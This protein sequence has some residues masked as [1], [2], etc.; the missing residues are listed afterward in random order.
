MIPAMDELRI[1][2]ARDRDAEGLISLIETVFSEYPGCVLDV[3][4]EEPELLAIDTRYRARNGHFWV[5]ERAGCIVASAGVRPGSDAETLEL[6]K[7]YVA[8][9]L[10]RR[11]LGSRLMELAEAELES[12]GQKRVELWSDTRFEDAHRLYERR[13]YR[14]S[15]VTRELQ[16]RSQSIEAYFSKEFS[17]GA[18]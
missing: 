15:S 10:R 11:G 14:R 8:R 12:L 1:R 6:K 13:G 9:P 2:A 5:A 18:L 17:G 3:E 7:L 16:D 4:S